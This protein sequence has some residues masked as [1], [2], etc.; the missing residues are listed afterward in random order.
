M[1]N[2]EYTK[3][4]NISYSAIP[5]NSKNYAANIKNIKYKMHQRINSKG[6]VD[7]QFNWIFVLIA[8]FVI[9]LF[10]ISIALSQ[11]HS[12]E[13]QISIDTMNQITTLLKGKQQAPN[14][15]SEISFSRTDVSFTCDPQFY[16]FSYKIANS[17]PNMLP[18]EIIFAPK[19]M[20]TNKLLVWSQSFNL[21][22]PV[23]VFTYVTTPDSII[24]IYNN[25]DTGD[26]ANEL[27]TDLNT[28]TNITHKYITSV[29]DYSAFAHR[30]I[31]CFGSSCPTVNTDYIKIVPGDAG[32]FDYGNVT[33]H[34][35]GYSQSQDN[36]YTQPYITKA[37]LYGAI[38][39]NSYDFY[40]CQMTRALTQFEIKRELIQSR[41]ILIQNDLPESTCRST[42]NET[43]ESEIISM[44]NPVLNSNNITNLYEQS[45]NLDIKN[46]YLSLYSCPKLY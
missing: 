14:V 20:N 9:F 3:S 35:K 18:V 4:Q 16:L 1:K 6:V 30:T 26:M 17:Q 39:S 19:L 10:I 13:N 40:R 46:T 8:G 27:F 33:F 29:N 34:T 44:Q 37:G 23:G 11:K 25:S 43:L 22:F 32:L 42:I 28:S 7:I 12:A 38:F 15:Y 5:A 31:V 2:V 36:T 45:N 41:M 24:L 21:G